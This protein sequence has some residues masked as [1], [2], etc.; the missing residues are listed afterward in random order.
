MTEP[1]WLPTLLLLSDFGGN[2]VS[3]LDA[4]Y[5]QFRTD[6]INSRPILNGLPVFIRIDPKEDQKEYSFWHVTHEGKGRVESQRTFAIRRCERIGWIRAAID[7]ITDPNV[8]SWNHKEGS[9]IIRTYIWLEDHDYVIV[10]EKARN[11][12]SYFLVTAFYIEGDSKRRDLHY[13]YKNKQP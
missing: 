2:V 10:L 4:V 11:K 7:N 8:K 12:R 5:S 3:Y 1:S 13:K 9:G 6:F